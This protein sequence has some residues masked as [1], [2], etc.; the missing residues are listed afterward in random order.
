MVIGG[1]LVCFSSAAW[2]GAVLGS[3]SGGCVEAAVVESARQVLDTGQPVTDRF[4]YA[5]GDGIAV[6]L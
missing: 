5:D 6:G 4:G 1:G 2:A 3:V